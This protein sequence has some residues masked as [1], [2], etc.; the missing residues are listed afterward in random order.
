[1]RTFHLD[2]GK[3]REDLDLMNLSFF[4]LCSPLNSK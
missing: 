4:N 2:P 1:M 3:E